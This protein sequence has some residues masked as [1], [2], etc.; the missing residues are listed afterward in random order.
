MALDDYE[1]EAVA[2]G[3]WLYDGETRKIEI[4]AFDCDY[5]FERMPGDDGRDVWEAY[6]LNEEGRLYYLKPDGEVLPLKPFTTVAEA[7][8]YAMSQPWSVRWD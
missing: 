5:F 6:S 4:V 1:G 3:S 8:Q 2:T 7:K